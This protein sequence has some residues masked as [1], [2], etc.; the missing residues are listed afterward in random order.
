MG[1]IKKITIICIILTC[2]DASVFAVIKRSI[3]SF[4]PLFS[5]WEI[6]IMALVELRWQEGLRIGFFSVFI[7]LTISIHQLKFKNP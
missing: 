2:F 5:S 1:V 7:Y 3:I 6:R 4:K